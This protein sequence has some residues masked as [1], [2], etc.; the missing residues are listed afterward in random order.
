MADEGTRPIIVKRIKKVAGGHHGGVWKIAYADFVTAMMA[1]FLLMWLLGSTAK[2]SL[3]G[4]AEYFQTPL[5]VAM[6]GGSGSGDSSSVIQGGGQ[7]LT[8]KDGQVKRGETVA[9]KKTYNIKAS[10]ADLEKALEKAEAGQL[11]AL[12]VK[13]EAMIESNPVLNKFKNQLLLD[14]TSEGLRIQIIDEQN[15]PMFASAK[16]ELQ[17]YTKEILREIGFALNDVPNRISLSGHTDASAY[18]SGE[19]GYSNWELSADRANASRKELILGGMIESKVLRVVGLSSAV[20]YDKENPY[21]PVN[22]RISIIV[23][24]KRAEDAASREG[25]RAVNVV[26]GDEDGAEVTVGPANVTGTPLAVPAPA[27]APVPVRVPAPS[28]AVPR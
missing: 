23:M 11:R 26:S 10:Q 13:I 17:P 1:F 3:S 18:S 28:A 21:N 9:A 8:R 24:N 4:I 16:A 27:P 25:A 6:G 19:K 5:L 2:G 12:K 7:D 15:R 20:L 22:R 14:I